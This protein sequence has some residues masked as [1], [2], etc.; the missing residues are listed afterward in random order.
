MLSN[1]EK[2]EIVSRWPYDQL[3]PHPRRRLLLSLLLRVDGAREHFERGEAG[4]ACRL[5]R[6]ASDVKLNPVVGVDKE[7]FIHQV[8]TGL[9]SDQRVNTY[10]LDESERAAMRETLV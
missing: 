8:L 5:L 9:N 2:N 1:D 4:E 10:E 6:L 7:T 3:D